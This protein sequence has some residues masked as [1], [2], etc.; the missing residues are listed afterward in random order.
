MLEA[1]GLV[2]AYPGVRAL[3]GASLT[4]RAGAV[5]ALVGET[6]ASWSST[7]RRCRSPARARRWRRG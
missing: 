2:K 3:D 1:R 7:A 6:P 5:H 4:A